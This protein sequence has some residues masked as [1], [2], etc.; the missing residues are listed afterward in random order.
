MIKKCFT[1]MSSLVF[2][3]TTGIIYP[4]KTIAVEDIEPEE[5]V[6]M[7]S[8]YEKHY[9][10]GDGTYTAY[11]DTVPLHYYE[12]GE[13]LDIDNTLIQDEN[14][15]YI[16]KNNSMKVTL[17]PKASISPINAINETSN[18]N[19]QMISVDYNGYSLSWN[20]I[21]TTDTQAI[22]SDEDVEDVLS[23]EKVYPISEVSINE[24]TG[25]ERNIGM[26]KLNAKISE[27][28]DNL[29]SSVLY[30]DISESI[31]CKIDIQ[32]N[33][34][35]ET[36][37]LE[38]PDN[39][40]EEY[41]YLIQSNGLAA[42]LCEDNSVVFLDGENTIFTIPA[43]FMF[44][45][46][47]DAEEN[48]SISVSLEE[49]DNGYIYTLSPDIDWLTDESR[50]YPVMIDP[51]VIPDDTASIICRYNSEANPNSMYSGIKV[52]GEPGNAYETY[53]DIQNNS[54]SSYPSNMCITKAN[55]YMRMKGA[56]V[57]SKNNNFDL[58]AVDSNVRYIFYNDNN[59]GK[60]SYCK[61]IKNISK[62][63]STSDY[64][65][66]IDITELANAWFNYVHC[67]NRNKGISQY[68]FKL[69][70]NNGAKTLE[71][72]NTNAAL[73]SDRPY[74]WFNY[75]YS[76]Y[77]YLPYNPNRYNNVGELENFQNN[78]NC[79]AYALQAYHIGSTEYYQLYPG[80][81]GI[82][83]HINDGYDASNYNELINHYR[84]FQNKVK[85]VISN[86][87]NGR[88]IYSSQIQYYVGNNET[89]RTVMDEYMV[90]IENQ[91]KR[92]A[93]VMDFNMSKYLNEN[94]IDKY[95]NKFTPPSAF[96]EDNERIIAMIAYYNYVDL[97]TGTL[98]MHY[99][100]RNGNGTCPV[101]GGNCSIWSNKM[102]SDIVKNYPGNIHSEILC[103]ETIYDY[104]YNSGVVFNCYNKEL[105]NFYSITKDADIFSSSFSHDPS[106]GA[107]FYFHY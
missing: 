97:Y 88:D 42:K 87:L 92:D 34:V 80:E 19:N 44:D 26:N 89:F 91:M 53:I 84:Y 46:S 60:A 93:V 68:G 99:Y 61:Y 56:S 64:G 96:N 47:D 63:S 3:A 9:Y 18:D 85:G 94:V 24:Q 81:I 76:D 48:Y 20:L 35:K 13:W 90:F 67:G 43:P 104:A 33:S 38:N 57:A 86:I 82:G 28:V 70:A 23:Y 66:T 50:V 45:S 8:E 25:V 11:I 103:D 40:L 16:N 49:T 107:T 39:I 105:V 52:G 12:N 72:Y 5:V 77:Y 51:Y 69:V 36:F 14:G 41:S 73:G 29:N 10:N 100:M 65:W 21:D 74:F 59:K 7:R 31:D 30:N 4:V 17:S 55:F 15:N 2:T 6:S 78:M 37:I 83:N 32:S 22:F 75:E 27:S 102:G 95:S 71:G 62:D 101:H 1:I 98:S 54:F 58:Y 79:Y 106:G